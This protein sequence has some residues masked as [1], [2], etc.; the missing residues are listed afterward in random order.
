[1][2]KENTTTK[3]SIPNQVAKALAKVAKKADYFGYQW[4][5]CQADEAGETKRA[6]ATEG[7]I[8][9]VWERAQH[10]GENVQVSAAVDPEGL[11]NLGKFPPFVEVEGDLVQANNFPKWENIFPK[12]APQVTFLLDLELLRF[13]TEV[14]RALHDAG[15]GAKKAQV[16][17]FG[18]NKPLQFTFESSEGA[19]R[20]LIMPMVR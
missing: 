19:V 5:L 18:P 14:L 2:E 9:I 12:D 4:I 20:A 10:D 17:Y 3:V 7:H 11:D 6:V 15:R 13:F 1:M 8:M 16:D